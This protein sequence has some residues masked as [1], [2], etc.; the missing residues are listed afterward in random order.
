MNTLPKFG[1][2][3]L[4]VL[5]LASCARARVD[6]HHTIAPGKAIAMAGFVKLP[7]RYSHHDGMTIADALSQAGG[8][9]RCRSCEPFYQKN[10]W[11][12]TFDQPPKVRRTGK[13]LQLPKAKAEWM[14]FRLQ[15]GDEIEFRH[16]LF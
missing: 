2:V 4:V 12:P 5:Q 15:P 8:Y 1:A 9:G 11:H 14:Q 13:S 3:L 10:G 7:G 16:V 6:L